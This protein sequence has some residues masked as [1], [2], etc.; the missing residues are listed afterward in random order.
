MFLEQV[1]DSVIAQWMAPFVPGEH[2]F[3]FYLMSSFVIASATYFWFSRREPGARPEGI[4]KGLFGYIF[5]K[6]VWLHRSALQD[7]GF[8][9]VNTVIYTG[10]VAHFLIS[11]HVVN[12]M[13]ERALV[14]AFGAPDMA[15][16][17]PS[18]TTVIRH[19]P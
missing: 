10:I 5:D 19:S 6:S 17:E 3:Y 7:Y 11:G 16:F 14:W 4:S 8:F 1:K 12:G 13:L 18:K 9:A 2:V 15:V